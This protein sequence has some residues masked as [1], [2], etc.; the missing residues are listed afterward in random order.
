MYCIYITKIFSRVHSTSAFLCMG[1]HKVDSKIIVDNKIF[2]FF[3]LL[4]RNLL[5]N[6]LASAINSSAAFQESKIQSW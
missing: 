3:G 6:I 5:A 2:K 4:K 1:M